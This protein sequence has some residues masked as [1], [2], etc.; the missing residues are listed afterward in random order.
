MNQPRPRQTSRVDLSADRARAVDGQD[1]PRLD[2]R[3]VFELEAA[4]VARTLRRLGVDQADVEDMAH[5]VFLAVHRQL[6]DYDASRPLRPWLFGFAF[7]I[8]SHYRRKSSR[9]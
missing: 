3:R 1:A 4:Y 8:A 9:P 6:C 7:R 2:F 5:E